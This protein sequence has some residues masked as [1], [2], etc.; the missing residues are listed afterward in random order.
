MGSGSARV[1]VRFLLPGRTAN[2]SDHYTIE[3]G[4]GALV[5]LP[6]GAAEWNLSLPFRDNKFSAPSAAAWCGEPVPLREEAWPFPPP[7]PPSLIP[8]FTA[9]LPA[10]VAALLLSALAVRVKR[11][12]ARAHKHRVAREERTRKLLEEEE[13]GGGNP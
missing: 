4:E 10:I 9:L 2:V 12:R 6:A 1:N 3:T 11:S 7:P 13:R 5:R 8:T